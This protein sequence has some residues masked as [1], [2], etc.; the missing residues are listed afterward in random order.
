MLY[1]WNIVQCQWCPFWEN[2][3]KILHRRWRYN[4]IIIFLYLNGWHIYIYYMV[5]HRMWI[6]FL[7]CC[8]VLGPCLFVS[9]FHIFVS[10]LYS[11]GTSKYHIAGIWSILLP[12]ALFHKCIHFMDLI[13]IFYCNWENTVT[14][15]SCNKTT[16][17]IC[18]CAHN[19]ICTTLWYRQVW[20][21]ILAASQEQH[22]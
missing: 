1:I 16:A 22:F 2:N 20:Q 5:Y 18:I 17:H 13:I 6:W 12:W 11:H 8:F 19:C 14:Q 3:L 15:P 21:T 4:I 9:I 10:L 7:L